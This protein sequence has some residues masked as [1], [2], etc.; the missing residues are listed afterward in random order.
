ML[1]LC[2]ISIW[3]NSAVRNVR[4]PQNVVYWDGA[5]SDVSINTVNDLAGVVSITPTLA[6]RYLKAFTI[7][8]DRLKCL[9]F[10]PKIHQPRKVAP[11][12]LYWHCE[13]LVWGFVGGA[14]R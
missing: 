3:V 7:S 9:A 11:V 2:G 5:C 4:C 13:Y 12:T 1:F 6:S 14:G 8:R 10:V